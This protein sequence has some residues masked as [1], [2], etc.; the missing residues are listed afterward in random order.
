MPVD[1]TA[2]PDDAPALPGG[3]ID[4]GGLP[5][6][7]AT[8]LDG[9]WNQVRTSPDDAASASALSKATG[10]PRPVVE[11]NRDE[12]QR[13]AAKP[14][15]KALEA[16]APFTVQ[17]L[18]ENPK[19]FEFA[20]DDIDNLSFVDKVGHSLKRGLKGLQQTGS[21]TALRAKGLGLQNIE[22]IEQRLA[23]GEDPNTIPDSLDIYGI[24]YMTAGQRAELK[25]SL[26][27]SSGSSAIN[28]GKLETEKRAIPQDPLVAR[29]LQAHDFAEFWSAFIEDP[30]SFIALVGAESLPQSAPGMIAAVP[31]GI[32]AGPTGVAAAMGA[33]SFGVD[34]AASVLQAMQEEG[35]DLTNPEAIAEATQN[36]EIMA[37]VG[38]K[39]FAHAGAVGALDA[40]S[41]GLAGRSIAPAALAKA[42]PV[43]GEAV[44]IA[45]QAG[46]QGALGATGEAL[47]QVAAGDELKAGEI[48]AE[49]FGEFVTAPVD[50]AAAAGARISASARAAAQAKQN[51]AALEQLSALAQA[52]KLRARDPQTFEEFVQAATAEGPVQDVYVS[53]EALMQ[54]GVDPAALAQLSPAVAEQVD[55]VLATGGELRIPVAEFATKV[56]G[57]GLDTALL[58]HLK[59]DPEGMSAAEADVFF[60]QATQEFQAQAQQVL[61]EK[62]AD[63][64]FQASAK[65]VE[66]SIFAQLQQANRFTPDVNN[67]YASLVRDFY[68]VTAQRLGLTP[69]EMFARYPLRV[70]AEEVAG[71]RVM[72]QRRGAPR[73]MT[74]EEFAADTLARKRRSLE[75]TLVEFR[76]IAAGELTETQARWSARMRTTPE[77]AQQEAA[78]V[79][80]T[81]AALPAENTPEALRSMYD[82][83]AA[84][85]RLPSAESGTEPA[86]SLEQGGITD[87]DPF[88]LDFTRPGVRPDGAAEVVLATVGGRDA[89]QGW[90]RATRIR[91]ADGEP[92]AVYR[93]ARVALAPEHFAL[94]AF[95]VASGNPSSGLGVWFTDDP[96]EA[97]TFGDVEEFRLDIRNPV[98]Y[99]AEELPGFD[100]VEEAHAWRETLREAG[101]DGLIVDATHLGGRRHVVAFE[102]EQVIRPEP[103]DQTLYQSENQQRLAVVHNLTA[104]NIEFADKLGG[105]PVPSLAVVKESMGLSGFGD[106]T[107]IGN[108]ELGDP[109]AVPIYDADAYAPRMPE[110]VYKKAKVKDAQ[111]LVDELRPFAAEY[112][113][114]STMHEAW[115]YAV[116][117]PK[118]E[119]IIEDMLR[120]S[121]AMAL[122]L[123]EQGER[124]D[125]IMRPASVEAE[126]VE[127]PAFQKFLKEVGYDPRFAYDDI[128]YRR[129]LTEAVKAASHEYAAKI[130]DGDQAVADLWGESFASNWIGSD[131]LV[132][133]GYSTRIERSIAAVGRMDVDRQATKEALDAKLGDRKPDFKAWVEAKV[134]PMFGEPRLKLR[135]KLVPYTLDNVVKAMT[136]T[137]K[138]KE[139]GITFGA[140][141]A[142]AAMS[143]RFPNLAKMKDAAQESMA[144]EVQVKQMREAAEAM[145]EDYRAKVVD[146]YNGR[147]W[148]GKVDTW[149]ALDASMRALARLMKGAKTPENLRRA[150]SAEDFD[151][152]EISDYALELGVDAAKAMYAVAV[153]YFEAKPQ[154]AVKLSEFRG[155]VVPAKTPANV[156][157]ILKKHGIEVRVYDGNGS[158][159]AQI[160]ATVE[161]R[162]DLAQQGE[163]VLFQGKT[164]RRL[165]RGDAE[166]IEQFDITKT[167]PRALFG[168]G[169]YLTTSK[170]IAGDYKAKGA[171]GDNGV[172]F[173]VGGGPKTTKAQAI[174]TYIRQRAQTIDENGNELGIS[175]RKELPAMTDNP[176]RVARLAHAKRIVEAELKTIEVRKLADNT[177]IFRRKEKAGAG[178]VLNVPEDVIA[179]MLNAE[180]EIDLGVATALADALDAVGDRATARD[181]YRFA[182][183]K[184]DAGFRPT[185]RDVYT[186]ITADSDLITP[187]GQTELRE[188]LQSLGYTGIRY[189]GGVTMG[190]AKH[191]AFVL[192]DADLANQVREEAFQGEAAPRGQ[193][194]FGAG[195]ATSPTTIT[196]LR[197]ADL[198]TF[199]HE[200]GHFFLEVLSDIASRPDAPP[201]IVADMNRLLAWFGVPDLAVWQGMTFEQRRASHEQFARGFEAYLF[202]GKAP[203]VEV[204]G[205]FSRFRAW[206]INVYRSLVA[207]NVELTDEVR[208]V[209]DRMIATD[210]QI[211]AAEQARSF[212]PLFKA[213]EE[214]GLDPK[215]WEEYQ[216]LGAQATEDAVDRLQRRSL[217]D[218]QWL[219]NARGRELRRLQQAAAEKRKAVRREVEEELYREPVY[220]AWRF[221]ANGILPEG[222][223]VEGAK[224]SLEALKEMY[225]TD[226][227]AP[228]RY[229]P[230][231]KH[232]LAG[233]EGLHPDQVAELF[234]L[235]SGDELVRKLLAAD[236]PRV[237]IEA[238]TDQRMLERYGDLSSPE[239]MEKA[240]D[241]AIHNTA[242]ARF[243]ATELAALTQAKGKASV[244]AKAAKAFAE[245]MIA[246]RKVRDIRP[247]QHAAAEARAGRAAD[248]ALKA[249]NLVLA[250]TE[251]RNQLVNTYAARTAYRAL[252]EID[253]GLNY[254]RKFGRE[255]TR[256]GLDAAYLDQIDQLLERFDLRAGV[257]NAEL[258]RRT[259]L[260]KWVESQREAGF[261]PQIG[262]DLLNEARRQHYR[263]LTLEEFRGLLDAVKNIEH[264]GRLKKKLLTAKDQREF[265]ERVT[266]AA[267]TIR[268]NARGTVPEQRASDRGPLVGISRWFA[269]FTA[270]HRK[271]ASLMRQFDGFKDGGALW[272]LLV[273]PMNEAGDFEA[274]RREK[275][276]IDLSRLFEPILKAGKLAQKTFIP[277]I[278]RSL[279]REERIGVALNMGNEVNRERVLTGEKW[280]PAQLQAVLST[281]TQEEWNFVQ[282]VWDYFESYRPEIGEKQKRVTGIEPEWVEAQQV[283][284][285]FGTLRGGYYPIKYDPLRSSRAEADTAAEVQRQM[286]RGLYTRAMTRRG[287]LE[288][289]AES[290]GRPLRY[291]L[292][293][294]VEHVNQVVH[295][296]AWHEF[297]IDANRLLRADA[298]DGAIREHYG[299]AVL[300]T[301]KDLMTDIAVGDVPAASA[302]EQFITHVRYGATIVGLGWNLTTAALQPLGLS[303][304]IVRIGPMWVARGMG[305]WLGSAARMENKAAWIYER[306]EFMRLRGKTLQREINEIR[307]KV[308]GKSSAVEASFFWLIQKLQ[309]V[310][311]IPTWLGAYEKAMADPEMTE[312]KAIALADQ[313]VIDSQGGGQIKDL[314][315]I[316]RGSPL[317]KLWT[318]FYSYFSV[319]YNLAAERTRA[320]RFTKPLDVARLA[321]D[322]LLLTVIPA[323][324]GALIRAAMKGELDDE[325]KIAEQIARENANYLFGLMI[326]LREFGAAVQGF[327][328]YT[329]P[330][331]I[332]FFSEI[333]KLGKQIEQGEVDEALLRSLN[334]VGGIVF[335]YPAG[336]VQRTAEGIVALAKGETANPGVLLAGPPRN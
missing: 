48:G 174:E 128:E 327:S 107:L 335:H 336:Q 68:V 36:A 114:M 182:T 184:D 152:R 167:D 271:F 207:L 232:G 155:A 194:N 81:L 289:R 117:N 220:A 300:R 43:A 10:L 304:S 39:A 306:S 235:G 272:E 150:L 171:G 127:M 146:A 230:V 333:T 233:A 2:L 196:L 210:E 126:F 285:K 94:D 109:V 138:N 90:A 212:A 18:V 301:L 118:P 113:D 61:A 60:Q 139:E 84:V 57:T 215:S 334:N 106:I 191:E 143:K 130:A 75:N 11:R 222:D 34:Y 38:Q 169:I 179:K 291:D 22:T 294:I 31:A 42:R 221:L 292:G 66:Q 246:G 41:G 160:Q 323:T 290:T 93:G 115:D 261:E 120:S 193:I 296:L 264:L 72:D 8:V 14:D 70:A 54:S 258:R 1:L 317:M 217:R 267:E 116:N 227:A 226:P 87:E 239:A 105:L 278:N 27:Y 319:T 140:G 197:N 100:T 303:Q 198:S 252:D 309:L 204:Q 188:R 265:A 40:A 205:L 183:T 161:L 122:Y 135:G 312:A 286:E 132:P 279:T 71:Q 77:Q 121:A 208:G 315:A 247:A 45:G 218:M 16:D 13:R 199:L 62:Q 308:A 209:F 92:A 176:E 229:L 234:G 76:R 145:L 79:E 225:G 142:R 268:E 104:E 83:L 177:I 159:D 311:D 201:E 110:R 44:N 25:N 4:F 195:I 297:L 157:G 73:P 284:T 98:T 112:D 175:E 96:D 213:A 249:G 299:P 273:R 270:D 3:S 153:P 322:Y 52:S 21:A 314:A 97:S 293:V 313:A 59:T 248:K 180:E 321:V 173:R 288:A 47:G 65:V 102:P 33:G 6:D 238:L 216:R 254:L 240:A 206:L 320:T 35:I 20:R 203:N 280:T 266:E 15:W 298:I 165:Y 253:K 85:D 241:E 49:F 123:H 58:P 310:A 325:E 259:S 245:R 231:G 202:E 64:A 89:A 214:A 281:L 26:L 318:N 133:F 158:P 282:G 101:H 186:G 86:S 111:R 53:A 224:L 262:E 263:D 187:E 316:Q 147:D 251:K 119:R 23:A 125:P 228:W 29:A 46:V 237:A 166:A 244:L 163:N 276:T 148:R 37:R 9:Q 275:A 219:Q 277:Q 330:G 328:G 63:A 88:D 164:A 189:A 185:Y 274:S 154:R 302:W 287:H 200:S 178:S 329:G 5:D 91:G 223:K 7:T 50:V 190:G 256:K 181:L 283:E 170:R 149:H 269:K 129:K 156:I 141:A 168:Q 124:V 74:L 30:V 257:T 331:G 67:A 56:A 99:K 307:N 28:I 255:G 162:R 250:A 211:K 324:L 108:A 24:R 151:V 82:A 17:Q 32:V 131:G 103:V 137:V 192:W 144:D 12:A 326:G 95:G 78:R 136:G 260:T 134:L 55:D 172:L 295:D 19:L 242:R 243:V 80:A 305:K 236:P 332:R 69:E 51:A